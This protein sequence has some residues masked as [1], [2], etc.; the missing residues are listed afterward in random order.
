[1]AARKAR[2]PFSGSYETLIEFLKPH[3]GALVLVG[4]PPL[5][6]TEPLAREY[7]DKAASD[8]ND[9]AIK[10]IATRDSIPFADVRSVMIDNKLTV[11]GVHLS[12]D[13]YQRWSTVI[14]AAASKTLNCQPASN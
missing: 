10:T 5:E 3:T 13:G 2:R 4:I 11:D 1:M 12:P 14:F 8:E 7:F 6:M 9:R